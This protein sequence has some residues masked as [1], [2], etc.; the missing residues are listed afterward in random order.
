MA[1]GN[2]KFWDQVLAEAENQG[3]IVDRTSKKHHIKVTRSGYK[4]MVWLA[5]TSSEYRGM[6]NAIA[7]LRRE[8]D[9]EWKGH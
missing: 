1:S 7:L 4:P 6:K 3:L 5:S 2:Q 9:F 8:L